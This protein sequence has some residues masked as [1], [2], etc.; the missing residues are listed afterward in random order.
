MTDTHANSFALKIAGLEQAVARISPLSVAVS[1]GVDSMTLASFA[2]RTLGRAAVA[3]AHATSPAVPSAALD[4]IRAVAAAENWRLTI[5]DAGEL[6]DPNYRANPL[7]RCYF[8][9]SNLY[10]TLAGL[11]AGTIASGA[12]CDD[13]EDFR[14]GLIAAAEHGVHHPYIEGGFAKADVRRLARHLGHHHLA[15]L[16]ASPCLSSRVETGIPIREEDLDLID[17]VEAWCRDHL[18]PATV[19]CR[20]R[21]HGVVVELD[22]QTLARLAPETISKL[23]QGLDISRYGLDVRDLK[24][25]AYRRGSAFLGKPR[26][27]VTNKGESV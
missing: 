8:C 16:A 11:A 4:R 27:T 24:F 20:V 26:S 2:H 7:N 17:I 19:R 18:A 14:P 5:V 21:R 12:N 23:M 22:Q 3:I 6:A 13:L 10:R 25:A 1:G 9:K 15:E